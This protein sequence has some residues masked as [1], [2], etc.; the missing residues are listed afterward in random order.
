MRIKC[1][2]CARTIYVTEDEWEQSD[3]TCK[4]CAGDFEEVEDETG[5]VSEDIQNSVLIKE[6]IHSEVIDRSHPIEETTKE[7]TKFKPEEKTE[8][9]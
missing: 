1:D 8:F 6:Q 7:T 5:D 2:G 3:G 9:D 4:E